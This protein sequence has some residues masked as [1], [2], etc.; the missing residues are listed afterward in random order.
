ME[1]NLETLF[2]L[3]QYIQAHPI[4]RYKPDWSILAWG[5]GLIKD[6]ES[7]NY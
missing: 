7:N 3:G 2:E 5:L 4:F 6:S 1:R